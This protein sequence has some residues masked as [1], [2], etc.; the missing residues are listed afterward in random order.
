MCI[1]LTTLV[2]SNL[3]Y[4]DTSGREE[5]DLVFLDSSHYLPLLLCFLVARFLTFRL[6]VRYDVTVLV[7]EDA[8]E[9]P[10]RREGTLEVKI[11]FNLLLILI[12]WSGWQSS[13]R[14]G[15]LL[16]L[17][18]FVPSE[19]NQKINIMS[20]LWDVSRLLLSSGMML[21]LRRP[22]VKTEAWL[23]FHVRHW[24]FPHIM[25]S[26]KLRVKILWV[27]CFLL[28]RCF[29]NERFLSSSMHNDLRPLGK[30][31]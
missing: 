23:T 30:Q 31:T 10:A 2:L 28:L 22:R 7:I 27:L 1:L 15:W 17:R 5:F 18:G 13:A 6:H 14:V 20:Q 24:K 29:F 9:W 19:G 12:S 4:R 3:C 11:V 26:R 21:G 16:S 8:L 25:R